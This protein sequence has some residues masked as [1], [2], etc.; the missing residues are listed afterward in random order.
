MTERKI[1]IGL[2]MSTEYLQQ[3]KPIWN[4]NF[5]E[6]VAAKR[7]ADWTWEYFDKFNKAPKRNIETIFF[8]KIKASNF[9]K[10]IAEE[11]EEDILPGLSKEYQQDNINLDYLLDL[12]S[13]YFQ[14]RNLLITSEQIQALLTKGKLNEAEKLACDYK[15]ITAGTRED[16]DLSSEVVL[17]RVDKAFNTSFQSVISYPKLLGEF[18]NDQLIRGAFVAL[19]AS[20]KRGKTF[21]LLDMAL[22]A[23]KTGK[24]VAFFQAGD[25]TEDQQLKRICVYLTKK[26]DL[27]QYCGKQ[28]EPVRDCVHNQLN[29]CEK[30][31][32]E[33]NFGIFEGRS[34]DE[35][36]REIQL[37]DL[38]EAHKEYPEYNPCFNCEE[39]NHKPWG[40]VWIKSVNVG[41]PLEAKEA[42]VAISKFF[43]KNKL[44]FKLS[45]HA[46][47]T[48]S[49][50]QIQ[51]ILRIW[52]KQDNFIPD[53][54]I[55]DYADLL[56][57]ETKMEYRHQQNDIWKGLR[58][59]S[60]SNGNPLVITATQADA[61]SY[62]ANRLKLTN[63]SEDK[64]KYAHVTAMYGLNQ[65]PQGREKKLGLMRINELVKREGDFSNGN[66]IIIL[67]NLKR[68]RPFLG[69]FK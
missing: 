4:N 16:L 8:D 68:G 31:E 62:E 57:P 14:E 2:I 10:D 7:I 15:P 43:I 12:T 18:W 13:E 1:I 11:I 17:A 26:S 47:G 49:V 54:I 40:A 9:P 42:K 38:I 53:L 56:V 36:R 34:I 19:M 59:L 39:Y 52:E 44:N 51:G 30:E 21:W 58:N 37:N 25:M 28:W 61:K 48:L 3:V 46:N 55:V 50:K 20:E 45:S 24:K 6:S 29:N 32:R 27:S 65:D 5:L 67:Q 64:R 63:F 35:L 69:S 60:Q 22:R 23:C 66:E 41:D 33:C